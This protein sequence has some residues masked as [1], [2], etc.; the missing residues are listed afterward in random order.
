MRRA[1]RT[2]ADHTN[3]ADPT[4]LIFRS[5]FK[6]QKYDESVSCLRSLPCVRACMVCQALVV[7]GFGLMLIGNTVSRF[8]QSP[9]VTYACWPESGCACDGRSSCNVSMELS[10]AMEPPLLIMYQLDRFYT[11]HRRYKP[12]FS[13]LQ[14]RGKGQSFSRE[15]LEEDCYPLVA[16]PNASLPPFAPCGLRAATIFDDRVILLD[17]E[18]QPVN[19]SKAIVPSWPLSEKGL[20]AKFGVFANRSETRVSPLLAHPALANTSLGLAAAATAA[21]AATTAA[22]GDEGDPW[23]AISATAAAVGSTEEDAQADLIGWLRGSPSP[24]LRKPLARIE[25]RLP[26]GRY[27]L[28]VRSSFPT[29][30]FRGNKAPAARHPAH[31]P[32]P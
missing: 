4:E 32:I 9:I 11:S 27:T 17:P 5:S 21:A 8:K 30:L 31:R 29:E 12:S 28:I 20:R 10:E 25:A 18:G 7:G 24:L 16:P 3:K 14:L 15:E 22:A 2:E 26:A 6:Q 1:D 19:L 23:A 13:P